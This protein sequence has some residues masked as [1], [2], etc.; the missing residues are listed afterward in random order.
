MSMLKSPGDLVGGLL[1]V[2]YTATICA[3]ALVYPLANWDMIAYVASVLEGDGLLGH[4]MHAQTYALVQNKISEGEFLVL[5]ADRPYRIA[6]HTDPDAFISML[7]FYRVKLLYVEFGQFLTNATDAVTALRWVSAISAGLFGLMTLSWLG[8]Q[9]CL[10]VAPLAIVAMIATG[11]GDLA[12]VTTP[13]LFSAVFLVAGV[14]LYVQERGLSAG[15]AFV[16][17]VLARPD[18]LALV[19]VFA[20]MSMVIRPVS[21]GVIL[22]FIAGLAAYIAI[23][24]MSG[25]PGWWVQM[26]FTNVEYVPTLEGFDPQFSLL[27]YLK[28]VVQ[29]VVRSLVEQQWPAVLVAEIFLLALMLRNNFAFTRRETVAITSL[30]V[31]IPAKFIVFPLYDSRFFFANLI[32]LALILIAIYGRQGS[33]VF[34]SA[35]PPVPQED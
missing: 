3:V 12:R 1:L 13:D 29:T 14:L 9:R 15:I 32:A 7:G 10:A 25:H 2:I 6:Q 28:I 27:V 34:F 19:G 23:S 31:S 26:W 16:L 24:R 30:L 33:P 20:V 5:T 22:G 4:S 11:F 17:A 35:P 18:H 8:G 21:K